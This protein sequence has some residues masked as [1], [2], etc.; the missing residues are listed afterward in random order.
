MQIEVKTNR[1]VNIIV[2]ENERRL[3][4]E[5]DSDDDQHDVEQI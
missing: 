1:F 5:S 2:S 3:D 4:N